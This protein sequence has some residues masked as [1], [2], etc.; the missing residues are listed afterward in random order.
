[1]DLQAAARDAGKPGPKWPRRVLV[2]GATGYIGR[3]VTQEL[4]GAGYETVCF[5]RERSGVGGAHGAAEVGRRLAGAELR[6]GDVCDARSVHDDGFRGEH[7]DAVVS[8]LATRTGGIRDAWQ[9]EYAAAHNVLAAAQALGVRHFVLLSAI[10]VQKP[11]LAFQ[12]AKLAFEQ[13]LIAA[14]LTWSIVR[15][16]AFFKSL[17]GQ[18]DAVSRGKPYVMFGDGGLTAC[19]PISERDLAR[20]MVECLTDSKRWNRILPIGGP[21]PALSPRQQGELLFELCG[22]APRFRRVPLQVFDM[23][24]ATLT[25]LSKVIPALADKAEFAR[26]GRYYASESM[27]LWN[28]DTGEYDA[29]STPSYGSDTLREFYARALREGLAEHRLGD[30][31]MF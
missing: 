24:I 22:R 6:F 23:I 4:V 13:A 26:I 7:F 17:A 2:V 11:R 30:H 29:A 9:I 28:A 3:V 1:M 15:P 16:T 19:T 31:S 25:G 8:C 5:V 20:F 27:L 21:G 12:K 18:L 14:P 10:C